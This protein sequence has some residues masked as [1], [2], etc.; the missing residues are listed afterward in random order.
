VMFFP[1]KP[2]GSEPKAPVRPT[3]YR[4]PAWASEIA[5]GVVEV[6]PS[7]RRLLVRHGA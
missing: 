1:P 6:D 5:G 3:D 2:P 4:P 7:T